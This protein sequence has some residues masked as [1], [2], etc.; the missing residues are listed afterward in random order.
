MITIYLLKNCIHCKKVFKYILDNTSKNIAI[1]FVDRDVV[2]SIRNDE[3]SI[4]RSNNSNRF[5]VFPVAFIGGMNQ[6]IPAKNSKIIKGSNYIINYLQ[7][8]IRKQSGFGKLD[9][10]PLNNP[11]PSLNNTIPYLN[12]PMPSL[13]NTIPY[14]NNTETFNN[15]HKHNN[16]FGSS[17]SIPTKLEKI[18]N[19][20]GNVPGI[21]I[22]KKNKMGENKIK[23]IPTLKY[24]QVNNGGKNKKCGQ[25]NKCGQKDSGGNYGKKIMKFTSP[26]GIEIE[27]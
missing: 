6:N 15:I 23:I 10:V 21:D 13:N 9:T 24:E 11:I 18:N 12:N 14:L 22:L 5:S 3:N 4:N 25:T 19:D 20:F 8:E 1:I 2:I 7:N 27:F 26:L 16:C 17:C